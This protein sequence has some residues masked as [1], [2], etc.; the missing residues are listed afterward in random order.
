[1]IMK[2]KT[3]KTENIDK[4][5]HITL[6]RESVKNAFNLEMIEELH[7]VFD[8]LSSL[9]DARIVTLKGSHNFF[10]SGADLNWMKES[11][12]LDFNE[13][14]KQTRRLSSMFEKINNLSKPVIGLTRG[15]V[16]GGGI[17]LISVCDYIVSEEKTIFSISE[18]KLGLIPGCVAPFVISKIG[19]SH[20][21]SLFIS[22]QKFNAKK[23]YEIGLIHDICKE[24]N[25]EEFFNKKIKE[26][27]ECGEN[28]VKHAKDLVLNL[29]YPKIL[30]LDSD[31]FEYS[32]KCLA[33]IRVEKEAQT[34]IKAFL[35][36]R[37]PKW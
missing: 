35:E 26:I 20:A 34:G 1:M 3:I 25:I 22:S 7:D 17:G 27:L 2:Y 32:S 4:V 16:I 28:A 37:K 15:G 19:S 8:K 33:K 6:D 23:A 10:C 5:F 12:N 13:N 29:S 9:S 14:L 30:K 18:V 11:I 24:S 36:K 21:R 31:V